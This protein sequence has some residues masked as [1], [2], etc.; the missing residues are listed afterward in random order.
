MGMTDYD[1]EFFTEAYAFEIAERIVSDEYSVQDWEM[2]VFGLQ[3]YAK[4]QLDPLVLAAIHILTRIDV[5]T[6]DHEDIRK[7]KLSAEL[8]LSKRKQSKHRRNLLLAHLVAVRMQ[9]MPYLDAVLSIEDDLDIGASTVERAYREHKGATTK[10]LS[11]EFILT[12]L[13]HFMDE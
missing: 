1:Q 13:G 5:L 6:D 7:S 10:P 4:Q 11:E 12:M 8:G 2:L 3:V 9:D